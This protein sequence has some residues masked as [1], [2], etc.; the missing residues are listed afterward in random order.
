MISG[1]M[2]GFNEYGLNINTYDFTFEE[3]SKAVKSMVTGKSPGNNHNVIAEAL[4]HGGDQLTE[5][6]L[7]IF[8][9]VFHSEEAPM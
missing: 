4:K 3:I 1:G 9:M 6:L 5:H 2:I 7:Q 8:N